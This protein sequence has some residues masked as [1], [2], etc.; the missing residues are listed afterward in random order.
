MVHLGVSPKREN[1]FGCIIDEGLN[2]GKVPG[3]ALR[4]EPYAQ[5]KR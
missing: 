4:K 1:G 5:K 3:E 2:K